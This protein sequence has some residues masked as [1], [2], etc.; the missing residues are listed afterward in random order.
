MIALA[1]EMMASIVTAPFV[2]IVTT[3]L[4]YDLRVRRER[5][6]WLAPPVLLA[7]HELLGQGGARRR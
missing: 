5:C 4:F 2:A 3:L 7:Q 1:G 6:W